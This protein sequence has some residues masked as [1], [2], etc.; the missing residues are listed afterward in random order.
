M[1]HSE[2]R[3]SQEA[4]WSPVSKVRE[5]LLKSLNMNTGKVPAPGDLELNPEFKLVGARIDISKLHQDRVEMAIID[6]LMS[7]LEKNQQSL[8]SL[9]KN[10]DTLGSKSLNKKAL[11]AFLGSGMIPKEIAQK[12]KL[13]DKIPDSINI[14]Q[15]AFFGLLND[16]LTKKVRPILLNQIAEVEQQGKLVG[17]QEIR[18]MALKQSVMVR[19]EISSFQDKIAAVTG[20]AMCSKIF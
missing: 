19:S 15:L 18:A 17:P 8:E 4:V 10:L 9:T 20:V 5:V 12:I 16:V 11:E 14:K 2:K 13:L 1:L 3:L 6:T 7:E